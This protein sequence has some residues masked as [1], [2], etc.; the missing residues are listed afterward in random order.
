MFG[1][2]TGVASSEL[3]PGKTFEARAVLMKMMCCSIES[4]SGTLRRLTAS[5]VSVA[6][7]LDLNHHPGTLRACARDVNRLHVVEP[8]AGIN[9]G[10]Q[11]SRPISTGWLHVLPRFHLQPI[12]H[13]VYV[14]SSGARRLRDA[15]SRGG[16]PA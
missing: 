2:G 6:M 4:A 3:P 8:H 13:V 11:A 9:I 10:G 16:L 15:L 14:G 1:M 12:N 7:T 5:F